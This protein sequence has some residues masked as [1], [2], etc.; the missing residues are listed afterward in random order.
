MEKKVCAIT[1]AYS[2]FGFALAERL[3]DSGYALVISGRDESKLREALAKLKTKTE[4]TA[5]LADLSKMRD[6]KRLV[7]ECVKSYGRLD[8]L[9]NNAGV[10]E[11]G[12]KPK[13]VDKIINTNVKGLEYCTHYALMKMKKQ[14]EGG[15]IVNIASTSGVNLKPSEK[16]AVYGSSKFAVMAYSGCLHGA[17]KDTKIKIIC[18]C[19]G[20]MKTELFRNN[21]EK[22]LPDFMDPKAAAGVLARL[23]KDGKYGLTMLMRKGAMMY[24]KDFSLSWKWDSEENLDLSKI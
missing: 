2:G 17:Y 6:C 5:I 15:L 3:A 9:V 10:F 8:V 22:V 21:P 24:S 20:G 12:T 19:P 7:D 14:K 18:F 11:E 16:E 4:V 13:L 23:I 1:G